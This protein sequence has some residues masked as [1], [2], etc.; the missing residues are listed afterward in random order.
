MQNH[1]ADTLSRLGYSTT[2]TADTSPAIVGQTSS[3]SW[4]I[5]SKDAFLQAQAED[6][7]ILAAQTFV[8]LGRP[9]HPPVSTPLRRLLAQKLALNPDGILCWTASAAHHQLVT[10]ESLIPQVLRL[11]H[12]DPTAG[13]YARDKTLHRILDKFW[14]PTVHADVAAYTSSCQPCAL[15]KSPLSSPR[16]PLMERP[17]PQRPFT[18]VETDIKGPLPQSSEGYRYILVLQ[19]AF[20]KFAEMHMIKPRPPFAASF[21]NGSAGLDFPRLSIQIRLHAI[22]ATSSHNCVRISAFI[23]PL[24]RRT[25]PRPTA[26]SNGST[27]LWLKLCPPS[28]LPTNAH[29]PLVCPKFSWLTT[30]HIMLASTKYHSASFSR[31]SLAPVSQSLLIASPIRLTMF[32]RLVPPPSTA[33]SANALP[34][35]PQHRLP[36]TTLFFATVCIRRAPKFGYHTTVELLASPSLSLAGLAPTL[37]STALQRLITLSAALRTQARHCTLQPPQTAPR[38]STTPHGLITRLPSCPGRRTLTRLHLHPPS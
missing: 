25:T 27:V 24:P 3:L 19:D 12:D 7:T 36:A 21:A 1:I 9:P 13:H 23:T 17:R 38:P 22:L 15:R 18:T 34:L 31:N 2:D 26:P 20:S 29:G 28:S 33:M 5:C 16:A 8:R 32:S 14:W 11:A 4:D 6:P 10:P 37:S 30:P 35:T